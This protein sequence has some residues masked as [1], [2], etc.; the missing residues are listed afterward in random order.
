MAKVKLPSLQNW[1]EVDDCLRE[2]CE[3]GIAISTITADMNIAI[4]D[5]KEVAKGLSDPLEKRKEQLAATVK[6]FVEAERANMEGKT[7]TLNFGKVGF[8]QSSSVSVPT[9]KLNSILKNLRDFGMVDCIAVK[10][11]VNKEVLEKYTDDE[12]ASVG[13]TRK[14]EDKYFMEI[15]VTKIK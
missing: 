15:D 2:I 5:A 6:S 8:R 9:S 3:V 10:E 7:K 1:D 14:V 11:T 4:N 12:I 13:A